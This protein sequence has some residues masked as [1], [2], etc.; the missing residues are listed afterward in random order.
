M[1]FGSRSTFAIDCEILEL[2]PPHQALGKFVIWLGG[3]RFGVDEP[4]ATMLANSIDEIERRRRKRGQH[5]AETLAAVAPADIA[6]DYLAS[7]YF[8]TPA[9]R[10]WG[11]DPLVW[12]PDG[13]AAFDDSSHILQMDQGKAVR[14]IAFRNEGRPLAAAEVTELTILAD[15]F[16]GTLAQCASWYRA[17]FN[18]AS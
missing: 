17:Q 16:Y 10:D 4:N 5:E 11:G 14:L 12:A 9:T 1:I 7:I 3:Q 15:T 8:G 13:D 18:P 6:N 2:H